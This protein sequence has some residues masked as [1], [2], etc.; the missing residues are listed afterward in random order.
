MNRKYHAKPF[1]FLVFVLA[2]FFTSFTLATGKLDSLGGSN[3]SSKYSRTS[4]KNEN[5]QNSLL[6]PRTQTSVLRD[7]VSSYRAGADD[8]G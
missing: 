3:L 5:E 4:R 1:W 7:P 8:S 2:I 6:Q